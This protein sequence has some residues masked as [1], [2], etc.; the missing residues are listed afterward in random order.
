[1]GRRKMAAVDMAR[2]EMGLLGSS[3]SEVGV[4][5]RPRSPVLRPKCTERSASPT[6]R[7]APQPMGVASC[8]MDP[9]RHESF[10]ARRSGRRP[11]LLDSDSGPC[12]GALAAPGPPAVPPKPGITKASAAVNFP[13]Y[14]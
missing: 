14:R 12:G 3:G 8:P 5:R 2:R 1:M 9:R 7:S 13:G 4:G 6:G 11:V 10:V